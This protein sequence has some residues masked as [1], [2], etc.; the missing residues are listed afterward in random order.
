MT[1]ELERGFWPSYNVPYFP[2]IYKRAGYPAMAATLSA[3]GDAY[4]KVVRHFNGTT[5]CHTDCVLIN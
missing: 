3:K 4:A 1:R 5:A 2:E